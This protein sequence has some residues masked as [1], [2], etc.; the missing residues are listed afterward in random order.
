LDA[1]FEYPSGN[2][3]FRPKCLGE[4][5]TGS[6]KH[7]FLKIKEMLKFIILGPGKVEKGFGSSKRHF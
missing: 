6:K 3:I 7:N 5:G 2:G 4:Q 1:N